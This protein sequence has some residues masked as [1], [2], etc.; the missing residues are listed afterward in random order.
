MNLRAIYYQELN[1]LKTMLESEI[2]DLFNP[3]LI[4]F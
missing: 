1:K 4:D 3:Q 2:L